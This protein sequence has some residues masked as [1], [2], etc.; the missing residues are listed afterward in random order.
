MINKQKK[1]VHNIWIDY[2]GMV[3]LTHDKQKVFTVDLPSLEMLVFIQR[4]VV[5]IVDLKGSCDYGCTCA[6][7]WIVSRVTKR[8]VG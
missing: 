6:H 7:V 8:A 5:P 1:L 2:N 3:E 4:K